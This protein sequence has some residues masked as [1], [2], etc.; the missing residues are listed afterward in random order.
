MYFNFSTWNKILILL[1]KNTNFVKIYIHMLCR[2][3][4]KKIKDWDFYFYF[5]DIVDGNVVRVRDG[6]IW[7]RRSS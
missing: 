1:F 5:I 2:W 4:Y 3:I 6:W 7:S